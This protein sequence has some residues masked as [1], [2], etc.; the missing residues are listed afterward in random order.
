MLEKRIE[1]HGAL[2][3]AFNSLYGYTSDANG[4]R[5]A[6][7]DEANLTFDEAKFMLVRGAHFVITLPDDVRR[8]M[9]PSQ[10]HSPLKWRP[11]MGPSNPK[12]WV[13]TRS[14]PA[15]RS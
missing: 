1:L 10:A 2:K 9:V 6:L 14:G 8:R 13:S 15:G 4:I 7:L 11:R 5:H 3:K 12:S